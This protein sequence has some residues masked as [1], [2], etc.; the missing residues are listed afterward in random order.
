MFNRRAQKQLIGPKIILPHYNDY[1]FANLHQ[2]II[3]FLS[4]SPVNKQKLPQ[5]VF[6]K[7]KNHYSHIVL[8][9]VDSL[10]YLSFK[11]F[12]KYFHLPTKTLISP[13]TSIF[14]STTAA[15]LSTF[16][17]GLL[18]SQH[19]LFEWRLFLPEVGDIIKTLPFC[20]DNNH[21]QDQL[22]N[23]GFDPKK[24]FFDQP[25]LYQKLGL[26]GVTSF[27]LNH[28]SYYKSA[29][30]KTTQK[31]AKPIP[32]ASLSELVVTLAETINKITAKYPK[33]FTY[34]YLD[35]LDYIGH[36]H[37]P[38]SKYFEA[39]LAQIGLMINHF[40]LSTMNKSST[41]GKGLLLITADHGQIQVNPKKTIYLNRFRKLKNSLAK[42]DNGEPI[43]A[44]GGPRD[45]FL[46]L[47]KDHSNTIIKYL[48]EKLAGS[49]SVYATKNILKQGWFGNQKPTKKFKKRLGDVLILPK[50]NQT[51]WLD[52]GEEKV[53]KLG[54]HGGLSAEEMLIPLIAVPF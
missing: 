40:L 35:T 30:A 17:T 54:H 10:G 46:H 7:G 29:F 45:V 51:A 15:A 43:L 12:Q 23:L 53:N 9:L 5:D 48:K 44:T 13:L 31:G 52:N 32:F 25:T 11:K 19:G 8:I 41:A 22:V 42:K 16:S 33:T 27:A 38:K 20:F 47:Q 14:P 2:A 4:P 21:Q 50:G 39:E 3:N 34:A 26:L 37:G 28:Q 18:P 1:C 24:I 36:Q 49:A 6:P